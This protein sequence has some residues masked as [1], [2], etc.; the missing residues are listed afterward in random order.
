MRQYIMTGIGVLAGFLIGAFIFGALAGELSPDFI[1]AGELIFG[2]VG[3]GLLGA[4]GWFG[5]QPDLANK[6]RKKH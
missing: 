2:T 5:A 4:A 1:M 3:A 6:K